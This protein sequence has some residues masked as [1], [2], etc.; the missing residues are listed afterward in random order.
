M[1]V[2]PVTTRSAACCK[3]RHGVSAVPF[4]AS[5]PPGALAIR[6]AALEALLR[7]APVGTEDQFFCSFGTQLD[8]GVL[9]K[10]FVELKPIFVD[11][12]F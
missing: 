8:T 11:S 2:S 7:S 9:G 3:V 4:P 10:T 12:G 1:T 5:S 6:G